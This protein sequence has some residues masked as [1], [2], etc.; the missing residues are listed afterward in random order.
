MTCSLIKSLHKFQS[1]E[2]GT[3]LKNMVIFRSC[4]LEESPHEGE[5]VLSPLDEDS[6][7]DSDQNKPNDNGEKREKVKIEEEASDAEIEPGK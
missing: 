4:E 5:S 2:Q 7:A 3:E 6:S 1:R